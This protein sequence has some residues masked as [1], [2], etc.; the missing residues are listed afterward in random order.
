LPALFLPA[1]L[2]NPPPLKPRLPAL[3]R[4]TSSY[5]SKSTKAFLTK[6]RYMSPLMLLAPPRLSWVLR[7]KHRVCICA[8]GLLLLN[9]DGL[10]PRRSAT[11]EASIWYHGT[12]QSK[13]LVIFASGPEGARRSKNFIIILL[14]LFFI[15]FSMGMIFLFDFLLS[16]SAISN[17]KSYNE[18]GG[19]MSYQRMSLVERMDI[20][21]PLWWKAYA[22]VHS[23]GVEPR[24][25]QHYPWTG[26]RYGP[27]EL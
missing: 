24:A 1:P 17:A 15:D 8:V 27:G 13:M 23:G 12:D 20:F 11:A 25:V 19:R 26:K 7:G 18:L 4:L 21:R 5:A 16:P 9:S 10:I 2:Q 14:S 22:L 3:V 6:N